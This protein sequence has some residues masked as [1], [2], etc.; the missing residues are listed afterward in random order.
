[1]ENDYSMIEKLADEAFDGYGIYRLV[2]GRLEIVRVNNS[3][4]CVMGYSPGDI[5]ESG[6][7]V[8]SR[9]HPDDAKRSA[10]A[11]EQA[12]ESGK[13][14]RATVR[15]YGRND[16][17]LYL[18]G[19]HIALGSSEFC[20]AFN[21]VTEHYT[22]KVKL[23]AIMRNFDCGI[24]LVK[25][26]GTVAEIA[27]AN[28]MFYD[29]LNVRPNSR[30][31]A[32]MLTIVIEDNVRRRDMRIRCA[33]GSRRIVRIR[34]IKT[35]GV[36]GYIVAVNDVTVRRALAKNRIAERMANAF[37]GLYDEVF[38]LDYRS[39]TTRLISSRRL[40]ERAA[41]AKPIPLDYVTTK[42]AEKYIHPDDR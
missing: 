29:V 14:V 17:I 4:K 8:W 38:E 37:A 20:I 34:L 31:L 18:D 2:N 6:L 15:R 39:M 1:M 11:C 40:P 3:Y 30:R 41:G 19:T 35:D 12:L 25:C 13:A 9:I 22:N 24:A 21:D 33:D 32:S 16:E 27:Y 26:S 36:G 23:E 28:D 10:K 42:W 5:I 7:N